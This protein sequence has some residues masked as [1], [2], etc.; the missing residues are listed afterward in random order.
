MKLS[1]R[2]S[3]IAELVP[4][5]SYLGDVG[6]D[7]GELPISL[8]KEKK[9]P[10]AF[11]I[12]NKVGPFTRLKKAI[13]EAGLSSSIVASLSDGISEIPDK[14]DC[15]VL[16]GMGG[17]LIARILLSHSE[18][19]AHVLSVV[20]DPHGEG[21]EALCALAGL[22]YSV[23]KSHFLFEEGKPYCLS[24]LTKSGGAVV[25]SA[26]ELY[27]GPLEMRKKDEEWKRYFRSEKIR[28]QGLLALPLRQEQRDDYMK[29][30]SYLEE[31]GL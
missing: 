4:Q 30:I 28:L 23:T 19:L 17:S 16:A 1:L 20:I 9:I 3:S 10:G 27:L 7:H 26:K 18:K 6:S 8:V 2:L 12:E 25:Y 14:V 21:E 13:D 24:Q 22:G 11:A 31:E 29:K 15:L 5:G